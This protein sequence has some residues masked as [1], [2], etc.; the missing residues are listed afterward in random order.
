M[1]ALSLRMRDDLKKKAQALASR[2]GV[3]LN[4]FVNAVVA[5]AVAQDETMAYFGDRLQTVDLDALHNRV[6]AFMNETADGPE[7]TVDQL[8]AAIG[9][10][11]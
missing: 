8:Q 3:S 6:L 7:P 4:N 9:T 11:F 10:R 1:A 5:A 2:E